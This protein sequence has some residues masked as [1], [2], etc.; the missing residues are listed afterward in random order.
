[1]FLQAEEEGICD[2][3]AHLLPRF[4]EKLNAGVE[5]SDVRIEPVLSQELPVL[6]QDKLQL[7]VACHGQRQDLL[8][9]AQ[10]TW[11][12]CRGLDD[13]IQLRQGETASLYQPYIV[14]AGLGDGAIGREL[15]GTMDVMDIARVY[16]AQ[17]CADWN[18][19]DYYERAR[20]VVCEGVHHA[21]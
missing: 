16:L 19:L 3:L 2:M 17:A 11:V 18:R 21:T 20:I 1:M 5:P 6:S 13:Q 7:Y 9:A 4:Q 14:A 12:T 10:G 8:G 15:E